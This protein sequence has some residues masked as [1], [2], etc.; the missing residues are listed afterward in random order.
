MKSFITSLSLS[1][2]DFILDAKDS[3]RDLRQ[4]VRYGNIADRNDTSLQGVNGTR[5]AIGQHTNDV[6]MIVLPNAPIDTATGLPIPTIA[7][8]TDAGFTVIKDTIPVSVAHKQ[9][10]GAEAH[11]V[12]WL[13][14]S[15]LVGTAPLY[16]GIFEDPFVHVSSDLGY[17]SGGAESNYYYG[18]GNWK[19]TPN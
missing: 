7:V 12:A 11:Q 10:S 18:P 9:T 3:E 1:T 8:A 13:G 15:K 17:V 16:Y 5:L 4:T 2:I 6:A 14:T 19:N